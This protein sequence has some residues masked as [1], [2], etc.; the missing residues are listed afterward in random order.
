MKTLLIASVALAALGAAGSATAQEFNGNQVVCF[1]PK[2]GTQHG[3]PAECARHVGKVLSPD[4]PLFDG[5]GQ[6]AQF[7][8]EVY[9]ATGE[10]GDYAKNG[11]TLTPADIMRGPDRA[12]GACTTHAKS[13]P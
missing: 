8:T 9:T 5:P 2:D 4:D 1:A 7:F 10:I 3:N 12:S 6:A 13:L 11:H